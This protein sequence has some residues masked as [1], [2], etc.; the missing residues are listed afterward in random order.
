MS[1]TIFSIGGD[2][3]VRRIGYGTM[4]LTGT[5]EPDPATAPVWHG[6]TDRDAA[7]A[8]LRRAVDLGVNLIDTA[9]AYAL[10]A[11]EELV[12]EALYPYPEGLVIA[13]KVGVARPSPAE[14]VPVGHPAYLRQQVE[15]SLR[16]LRTDRIDLLH[17]HRIDP[18][19]P[20]AEQIG[21]LRRLRDEGK[22]R[23]VALSEVGV[24]ELREASRIVPIA[25]VQN[26]Y[27][28]SNRIHDEVVDHAAAH[29]IAFLAFFPLAMG[30]HARAGSA[31]AEVAAR[32]G[33]T[34]GQV[35]L[36]WLLRR[37]PTLIPIPG[38]TSIAHLAENLA[39]LDLELP[40]AEF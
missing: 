37:S 15:L 27:S 6:P 12:A 28:V 36:A 9:D 25:A 22:I 19:V 16:R 7:K 34:P 38:T 35:A 8:V 39:A 2:L 14:W 26:Q 21:A 32:L 17:L 18:T 11:S 10:G 4:R 20:F 13:T 23:H 31:I 33:A 1:E 5:P 24:A 30:E 3:P 29:K 40:E